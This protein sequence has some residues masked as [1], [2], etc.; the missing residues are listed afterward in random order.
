VIN[1][2]GDQYTYYWDDDSF[3]DSYWDDQ[4]WDSIWGEYA[5][6]DLFDTDLSGNTYDAD[7]PPGEDDWPFITIYGNCNQCEAYIVDYFSTE[8]FQTLQSFKI[9]GRNYLIVS[10]VGFILTAVLRFKHRM[11]PIAE[12]ELELLPND[13]GALA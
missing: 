6:Y 5:C 2:A 4:D 9:Q 3:I 8:H 11:D 1:E 10:F 12:K 13:G 7:E